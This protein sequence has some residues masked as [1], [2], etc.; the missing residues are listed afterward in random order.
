LT[1][2]RVIVCGYCRVAMIT[3]A[4]TIG[5]VCT[6][7]RRVVVTIF[8]SPFTHDSESCCSLSSVQ[9]ILRLSLRQSFLP[10]CTGLVS[11]MFRV[12][13]ACVVLLVWPR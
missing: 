12:R 5:E 2:R 7:Y 1:P 11:S 13:G 4:G 6:D 10:T 9:P 8:T 3:T